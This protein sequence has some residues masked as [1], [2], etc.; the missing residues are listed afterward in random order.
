MSI[1]EAMH[2]GLP[3]IVTNVGGNPELVKDQYSGALI[4]TGDVPALATWI[5]TLSLD[6]SKRKL[7][8]ERARELAMRQFSGRACAQAY[9]S[10]YRD[11]GFRAPTQVVQSS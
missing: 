10:L 3:C 7:M 9:L 1:I 5:A 11:L 6:V 8:G 4:S 2:A